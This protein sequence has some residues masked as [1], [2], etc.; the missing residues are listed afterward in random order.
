MLLQCHPNS[1][2]SLIIARGTEW[3]PHCFCCSFVLSATP[4]TGKWPRYIDRYAVKEKV[5]KVFSTLSHSMSVFSLTFY[6]LYA[7]FFFFFFKIYSDLFF[8]LRS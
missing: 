6:D 5:N 4:Q 7:F 3:G 2:G 1:A 8:L